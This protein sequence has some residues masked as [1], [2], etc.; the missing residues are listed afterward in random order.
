MHAAA[1]TRQSVLS[2]RLSSRVRGVTDIFDTS[3][4]G[5]VLRTQ[6]RFLL[7]KKE[8]EAWKAKVTERAI[9]RAGNPDFPSCVSG[10]P[11]NPGCL[12]SSEQKGDKFIVGVWDPFYDNWITYSTQSALYWN[13]EEI[14]GFNATLEERRKDF[15]AITG[16]P[17]QYSL[18]KVPD[19]ETPKDPVSKLTS[20][21][22]T[23]F[24]IV[25]IGV[26]GYLALVY[27]VPGILGAAAKSKSAARELKNA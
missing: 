8:I 25:G 16:T 19:P 12:T 2:S 13:R 23:I 5:Y 18:P 22:T 20:S 3:I 21:I 27:V 6:E 11:I 24:W 17:F 7:T 10:G 15:T 14:D 4:E 1:A 26:V 9:G